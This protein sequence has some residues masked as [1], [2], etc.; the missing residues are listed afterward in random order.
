M[1]KEKKT[2][3][4]NLMY[5]NKRCFQGRFGYV[6][7]AVYKSSLVTKTWSTH[8][9]KSIISKYVLGALMCK[10][11]KYSQSVSQPVRSVPPPDV[12]RTYTHR[13]TGTSRRQ[14]GIAA[15]SVDI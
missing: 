15:R 12:P 11:Y 13:G 1:A 10:L 8:T 2:G 14:A 3:R 7:T 6:A 4:F 5:T 9:H